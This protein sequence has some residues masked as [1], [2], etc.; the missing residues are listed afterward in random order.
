M[1]ENRSVITSV[2][3]TSTDIKCP[4]C[5]NSIGVG[6][7]PVTATLSCPFCGL[8]TKLPT[9]QNGAVAEELD[10]NT[11]LQR[12]SVDWGRYKKII[13]CSNCGGQTVYD[14]EQVT[15]ACPFCGSTS[16]APAAENDQIMVPNAVI[17][18][19]IGREQVQDLFTGYL[20]KKKLL[21]KGVLD[22][23]L[24]NVV[25]IY[26]PFWTFDAYTASSYTA[27]RSVPGRDNDEQ[28]TGSWYQGF[29]DIPIFASD[30]LSNPYISKVQDFDFT[31]AVPYSS[32][33]LAGIPSERYTLG[34]NEGWER[35]KKLI[36][37][38]IRR[39]IHS[40]HCYGEKVYTNY[41][42][43]KFRCL[44]APLYLAKY[45]FG[46]KTYL[47]AINGQNGE[48]CCKAPTKIGRIV[49]LVLIGSLLVDIIGYLLFLLLLSYFSSL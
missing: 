13:V 38:K 9:P 12:A 40:T 34:L 33:Y 27:Y 11:A 36:A 43:V 42:N 7:D 32:K 26:L 2:N 18:F 16:V 25:G 15:G 19:S 21:K 45:K 29:D 10:F 22:C 28:F 35:T 46:K 47:V 41:Y 39:G 44:M 5:G 1:S 17:P 48:T 14:S 23:K 49:A 3:V 4:G 20:K 37:E 31:S 8:S 6:F 24:E 30:R